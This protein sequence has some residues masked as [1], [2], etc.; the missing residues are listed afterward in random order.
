VVLKVALVVQVVLALVH[1]R[2]GLIVA[3]THGLRSSSHAH[4]VATVKFLLELA[5]TRWLV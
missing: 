1:L 5:R 3:E 2:I 4:R